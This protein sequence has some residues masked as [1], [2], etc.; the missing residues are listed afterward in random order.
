MSGGNDRKR[1][2][3]DHSLDVLHKVGSD[4][5][6]QQK[7]QGMLA[8]TRLQVSK[9]RNPNV[10]TSCSLSK[11]AFFIYLGLLRRCRANGGA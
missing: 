10:G 9:Q 3:S 8:V 2:L 7:N 4:L 11:Y 6:E 1:G 5:Q